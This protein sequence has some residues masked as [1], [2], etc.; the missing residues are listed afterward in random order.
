MREL[1]RKAA[2]LALWVGA[3]VLMLVHAA[4]THGCAGA[5]AE[6]ATPNAGPYGPLGGPEQASPSESGS[7]VTPANDANAEAKAEDPCKPPPYMY[8]TKA[9]IW[10]PP[11][12]YPNA[13]STSTSTSKASSPYATQNAQP[14]PAQQPAAQVVP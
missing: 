12:C 11:E 13:S 5:R 3:L 9:P 14:P 6:G 4:L 10:I 2:S 8:A 1:V 7:V